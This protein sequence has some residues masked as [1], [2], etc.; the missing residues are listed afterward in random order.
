MMLT[1]P[2]PNP[3]NG[4]GL[5]HE[6]RQAGLAYP[7]GQVGGI[8]AADEQGVGLPDVG[9]QSPSS[10]LG[11]RLSSRTPRDFQRRSVIGSGDRP[12]MNRHAPA[13][14]DMGCAYAAV[15]I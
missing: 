7:V 4:D 14:P 5:V 6:L 1:F 11:A 9:I 8:A 15:G 13:R 3:L 2:A 12:L 10:M